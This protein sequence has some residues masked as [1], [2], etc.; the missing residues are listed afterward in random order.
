MRKSGLLVN[1]QPGSIFK[2]VHGDGTYRLIISDDV[3]IWVWC[4]QFED[5][6]KEDHFDKNVEVCRNL[7]IYAENWIMI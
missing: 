3:S 4:N 7:Y 1:I 6:E 5:I 2:C